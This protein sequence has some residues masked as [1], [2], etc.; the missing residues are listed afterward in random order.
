MKKKKEEFH[1]FVDPEQMDEY[2]ELLL[3]RE[4]LYKTAKSREI[5]Y[6]QEFG[7]LTKDVFQAKIECISLK[8]TITFCQKAINMGEKIDLNAISETIEQ[9]MTLYRVELEEMA[10]AN[11]NAKE[12]VTS[13]QYAVERSKRIYRRLMKILHPDINAKTEKSVDLMGLWMN[14]MF[15]YRANDYE[16]L[17]EL[18]VLA[19]ATLQR[20]GEDGFEPKVSK[21]EQ[22]IVKVREQIEEI[23]TTK[24]YTYGELLNDSEAMEAKKAELLKELDEYKEYGKQ[25]NETLNDLLEQGGVS[26][27]WQ[28]T[29]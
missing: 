16:K 3:K 11:Q 29:L 22:K 26:I 8:K 13:D 1:E 2:E 27:T 5:V 9:E 24:P 6:L 21:I 7:E 25:L 4:Q 28:M 20:L 18:E 23:I 17:E 10:E 14:I 19:N 15:A 12:A